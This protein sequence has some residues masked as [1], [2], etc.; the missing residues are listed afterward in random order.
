MRATRKLLLG[1]YK[2]FSFLYLSIESLIW[3][4]DFML[5][6][7]IRN[8]QEAITLFISS[9][10]TIFLALASN[11]LYEIL[12]ASG[13]EDGLPNVILFAYLG[14]NIF[15]LYMVCQFIVYLKKIIFS[16]MYEEKYVQQ[17]FITMKD[18]ASSK[19]ENL[20]KCL[21]DNSINEQLLIKICNYNINTIVNQCFEF[22]D[23]AFSSKTELVRAINFEVTFMTKSYKD[24]EI[25]IPASRNRDRT[26]P[27][28]MEK[29]KNN[30]KIYE[31]TVTAE[32]YK[33]YSSGEKPRMHIIEDTNSSD[34]HE[35]GNV[36]HFL[37]DGEGERIKS[38]IVMPI[39]SY[40]NELLGTLVVHCDKKGFFKVKKSKFWKEVLGI[41]AVE[42][43]HEKLYMDILVHN[44]VED[45]CFPF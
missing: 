26:Q 20:Q 40:K 3:G 6:K 31:N 15:A 11:L 19:G 22:F 2:V 27:R 5:M 16:S 41:F 25:T 33:E 38:S 13:G 45:S 8:K 1:I 43:S 9:I 18:L 36:Y 35:T 7:Y 14:I 28:S 4:Y 10:V 30:N 42:I 21:D 34:K 44:Q 39:I 24:H 17:A 12:K 37:Y 29:R 23:N 32:V